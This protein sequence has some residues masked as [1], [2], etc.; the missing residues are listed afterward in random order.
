MS[1]L[2]TSVPCGATARSPSLKVMRNPFAELS[3]IRG[4]SDSQPSFGVN[5]FYREDFVR[6]YDELFTL[7]IMSS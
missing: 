5:F 7:G 4:M 3:A 6:V 2:P 1:V